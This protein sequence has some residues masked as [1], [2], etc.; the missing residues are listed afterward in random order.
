ML[1]VADVTLAFGKRVLFKDVTINFSPGNCYG[2]IGANGSGKSTFLKILSGEIEPNT[3]E[4]ARNPRERIAMLQQDQNAFDEYPVLE[5]VIMGH[6]R[7]HDVLKERDD[8]YS[9]EDFSDEDGHRAAE[10]EELLEEMNG[11]EA[12]ADAATLLSGL[13]LNDDLHRKSMKELEGGEKVRVLL[14]QALFG[15]PDVLLL[16]EP[17]NNLD[18]ESITWLENFL[19]NFN[20]TVIVVSHD[21][22]FINKVCTHIADID[23]GKIM[24][25]AGN[26][27]FWA[28][29]IELSMK[30]KKDEN[31]K[32]EDKI[33]DLQSFIERFSSN[34]SKARQATS[35]KKLLE[36][37]TIDEIP[38]SSRRFPYIAFKPDRE[39]G[40]MVLAIENLGKSID[41]EAV[42]NDFN[43]VANRNDKIAFVGP[44]NLVKSVL[45][46]IVMGE[47]KEDSGSYKWGETITTAYFPKENSSFFDSER[48]L[49]SWLRQ[50][51]S[52]NDE[53]YVRG[54]LGRM[55]FS[56][57]ESL[58]KVN[59]LS[60]GERVR[61]MLSRMMLSGAN[62][63][64]L[65]DPTNHLDLESIT[66]LNNGLISFPG[67]LLFSSHDYQFI[68]SIANRI[69]EITPSGVID[70]VMTFE[71][72]INSGEV[73]AIRDEYYHGHQR[74]SI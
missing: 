45:F 19:Y 26:Y 7:M 14:A 41:G 28:Q 11:Y 24:V 37:L 5:T 36:K 47:M 42:L 15:N 32:K 65:D 48:N 17:T 34:A 2:L 58:K 25:Y 71:E 63:M 60:G 4:I 70:R 64:I 29:S 61:C 59:V 74:L 16:D 57:D 50:F 20:N 9:K 44:N 1:N 72:Y 73:R 3:G 22:H 21:R 12:E 10:L 43:L 46:Q 68:D 30:Q 27:D 69:V 54:F 38:V 8:I 52:N 53:T 51:T 56:G 66:S 18:I 13:G 6:K 55:L 40:K 49:I 35:R 67:V 31:K 39:C 23:F 62:A 33:K